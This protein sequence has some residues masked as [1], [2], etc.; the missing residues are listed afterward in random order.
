M[1]V[2]DTF[3]Y[4]LVVHLAKQTQVYGLRVIANLPIKRVG[5]ICSM[6]YFT[7]FPHMYNEPIKHSDKELF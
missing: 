2:I 1:T 7:F 3:V 4:I 6:S 5:L